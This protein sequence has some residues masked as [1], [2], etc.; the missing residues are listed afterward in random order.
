MII[1]CPASRLDGKITNDNVMIRIGRAPVSAAFL[2][3]RVL[4]SGEDAE[5][6]SARRG[7]INLFDTR[8]QAE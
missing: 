1:P 5:E 8:A 2:L 3:R 7:T 6:G 4:C